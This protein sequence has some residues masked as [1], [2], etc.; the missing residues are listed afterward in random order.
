M[1][2]HKEPNARLKAS[3]L[4]RSWKLSSFTVDHEGQELRGLMVSMTTVSS[5]HLSASYEDRGLRGLMVSH[6]DCKFRPPF[7]RP[8]WSRIKRSHGEP[9][10]LEAEASFWSVV[11]IADR[12][13]TWWAMRTWSWS[14]LSAGYDDRG[15]R[16]LMV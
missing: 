11:I 3:L 1:V 14:L 12:E 10:G 4:M 9:W 13:V 15:S 16:S 6:E 2:A 5:G 7:G 8:W